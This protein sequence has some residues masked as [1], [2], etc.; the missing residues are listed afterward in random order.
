MLNKV[1]LIGRLGVD[2]EVRHMPNGGQV[3]TFRL[4]TDRR[5]KDKNNEKQ[6]ET[7]W[8]RITTFGKL[9]EICGQYLSKGSLIYI[10]GRI[11]TDKYQKDGVDV[12]TT[13]IIAEN[14][15]M[16]GG[17]GESQQSSSPQQQS[18]PAP[19]AEDDWDDQIPF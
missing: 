3:T 15:T 5:W 16:L 7:E 2:P 4:A 14:M 19:P 12:Y 10:D 9:A 13:G 11:K 8:H 6:T 17:K 1:T 18:K